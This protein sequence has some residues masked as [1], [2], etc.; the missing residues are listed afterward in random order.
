MNTILILYVLLSIYFIAVDIVAGCIA[1]APW[2][3]VAS[4]VVG[5][6]WPV[7]AAIGLIGGAVIIKDMQDELDEEKANGGG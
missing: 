7:S 1:G 3:P 2:R 5:F 4:F 6:T